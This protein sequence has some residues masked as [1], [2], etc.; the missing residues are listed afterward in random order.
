MGKERC[1]N[2]K[3]TETFQEHPLWGLPSIC[4]RTPSLPS[5]SECSQ[6][7]EGLNFN[8]ATIS[9]P[10]GAVVLEVVDTEMRFYE[11]I[12]PLSL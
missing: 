8:R 3:G 1:E 4:L 7:C 6:L 12:A 2:Q 10:E 9:S 11:E 5:G